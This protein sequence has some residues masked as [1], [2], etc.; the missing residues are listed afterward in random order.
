[1]RRWYA[2]AAVAA[3]LA[4]AA[5]AWPQRWRLAPAYA[6]GAGIAH[7]AAF[8]P[9][10]GRE[11][12][13]HL[14]YPAAPGGHAVTVGG[15]GV[16]FGTEAGREAP[17]REGR[18]PLVL[19]SH[20]AGGN[21]GQYGWIAARL[22]AAGYAVA[23]PNHP[24]STSGDA[25]AA[26]AVK[27]WKRPADLSAVLSAIEAD[28]ALSW[29]DAERAA[30]LGFSAGGYTALAVAG[31]LIDPEKL[32]AF[33]DG[34]PTGMSDCAFLKAGGVDL[35]AMDL[36]PAGQP[37]RDARVRAVVAIDPGT[38]QTLTDA[39]LA[40]IDIPALVINL[41][42]PG[43]IPPA[44]D[45][46]RAA[47]LIPGGAFRTV[48]DAIHFSFLATCKPKGRQILAD[49]GEP[50]PLCD[51]GGGRPRAAIHDE[52]AETILSFLETALPPPG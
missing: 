51:D 33:C 29:I 30:A 52:L 28:P 21:A 36:S 35:H 49:E 31:A 44:V 4:L 3:I 10:R 38:V 19:V 17:R 39:S 25:S 5:L 6:G 9:E 15:N 41:G 13:Y 48:P 2:L 42:R 1:M 40:A 34:P 32:A 7:G 45:A 18:F 46:A 11:V 16:F 37:H 23:I 26:E 14:W 27:L 22:A 24:G 43:A 20:G 12:S 50:D 8:A 47:A